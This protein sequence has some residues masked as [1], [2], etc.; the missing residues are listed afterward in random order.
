[1]IFL[2]IES[3]KMVALYGDGRKKRRI[4]R[5]RGDLLSFLGKLG[6][7]SVQCSSILDWPEKGTPPRVVRLAN[8][9]RGNSLDPYNPEA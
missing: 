7:N 9:I 8:F 1:M 3:G 4:I 5:S 6:V 2:T